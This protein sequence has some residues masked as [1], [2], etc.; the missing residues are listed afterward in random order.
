MSQNHAKLLL[1]QKLRYFRGSRFSQCF[2]LSHYYKATRLPITR[3]QVRFHA[4]NYFE[5]L[6]IVSTAF[7]LCRPKQRE[8]EAVRTKPMLVEDKQ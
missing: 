7:N 2:I 5:Y 1:S 8:Y 4:D 6:P 3:Y